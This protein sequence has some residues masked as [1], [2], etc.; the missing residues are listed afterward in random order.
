MMSN[1]GKTLLII[2]IIELMWK[3]ITTNQS[4]VM[5][6]QELEKIVKPLCWRSYDNGRVITAE[7]V[8]K[9]N[10]KLEKVGECYLV[11][12]IYSDNDCLEYNNPVTLGTAKDIAWT[13]YLHTIG[14]MMETV[15]QDDNDNGKGKSK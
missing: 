12:R 13:A 5:D 1:V 14:C 4:I 3:L 9:Y 15:T 11:H 2:C 8:L 10:L 7:T 6:K